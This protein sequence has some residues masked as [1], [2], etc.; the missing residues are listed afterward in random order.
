[1]I[2]SDLGGGRGDLNEP[3]GTGKRAAGT[4]YI[5]SEA[6]VRPIYPLNK[7]RV[8]MG[9]QAHSRICRYAVKDIAQVNRS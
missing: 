1:M 8:E 6:T 9:P 5:V 3:W 4:L 7:A 2:A